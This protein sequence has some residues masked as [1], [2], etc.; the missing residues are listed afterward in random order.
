VKC[1][2]TRPACRMLM[3]CQF[4]PVPGPA[5]EVALGEMG[6]EMLLG[7]QRAVPTKLI[8]A[9]FKFLDQDIDSGIRSALDKQG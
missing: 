4:L 1:W 6:R 7:G 9:G 3:S 8:R 2:L 5:A